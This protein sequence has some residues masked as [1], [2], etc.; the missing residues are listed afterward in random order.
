VR[1]VKAIS[2]QDQ[3]FDRACYVV[4]CA[5]CIPLEMKKYLWN[6]G[7]H[8]VLLEKEEKCQLFKVAEEFVI[9]R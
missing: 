2:W 7:Y 4:L 5:T 3:E 6:A 9:L 8:W 1:L